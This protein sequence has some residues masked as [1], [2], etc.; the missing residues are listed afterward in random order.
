MKKIKKR[1]DVIWNNIKNDVCYM[2]RKSRQTTLQIIHIGMILAI[3]VVVKSLFTFDL[4]STILR[5][6]I[7][8]PIMFLLYKTERFFIIMWYGD[9]PE[10]WSSYEE[11]DNKK[12]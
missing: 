3:F 4:N 7:C 12:E 1:F 2:K 11:S 5:L 8:M 10:Y 6:Y 9:P